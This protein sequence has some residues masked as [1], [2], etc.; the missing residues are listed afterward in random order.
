MASGAAPDA[1]CAPTP[2]LRQT[3]AYR[4]L[5][6]A[7]FGSVDDL[8]NGEYAFTLRLRLLH[9]VNVVLAQRVSDPA[10]LPALE[11]LARRQRSL[12]V[13]VAPSAVAG[14]PEEG[15]WRAAFAA[16]DYV[17]DRSPLGAP[18]RTLVLD[19]DADEALLAGLKPKTRY[20][21][22]TAE[23][24]GAT[25]RIE[26]GAAL[27]ARPEDL[28]AFDAV[29]RA[30]CERIGLPPLPRAM[31]DRSAAAFGDALFAVFVHLA[32][33][34]LGAVASFVL[35]GGL[36]TYMLNGSTEAGRRDF[37][38]TLALWEGAR[39]ARRRGARALDLEG[40]AD[41]RYPRVA[42]QAEG[43]G[44]FKRGFGGREVELMAPHVKR[45]A[46]LKRRP[47]RAEMRK[48]GPNRSEPPSVTA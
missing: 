4:E 30:N 25:A 43:Q 6:R 1:P 11:E 10:A 18:T 13:K 37:A 21:L 44:R 15:R 28:D 24:R 27:A 17:P 35:H 26:G 39:E 2:D 19:L 12:L 41:P 38:P 40:I 8:G 16:H 14:S 46:F 34:A 7:A 45:W 47:G 5:V 32:S 3:A 22:R 36:A 33:G 29:Y 23:R 9:F 20:N 48:G 42:E 31:V